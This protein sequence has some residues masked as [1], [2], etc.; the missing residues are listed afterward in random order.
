MARYFNDI[1]EKY[2]IRT[3][4]GITFNNS[5]AKEVVDYFRS[6]ELRKIEIS[7][8]ALNVFNCNRH[9]FVRVKTDKYE[10]Y[11]VRTSFLQ[12]MLRWHNL[13]VDLPSKIS[14]ETLMALLNESFH[15]IKSGNIFVNL[16][17]GEAKTVVSNYFCDLNNLEILG[18]VANQKVEKISHDD[19][20]T[21]FFTK[22]KFKMEPVVGD[23]CGFA[24]SIVNSETGFA[25]LSSEHFILRYVCTNGATASISQGKNK[26]VH[27][28]KDKDEMLSFLQKSFEEGEYGRNQ[29]I[30]K[31]KKSS[32]AG[33]IDF[34][35]DVYK[36]LKDV[37]SVYDRTSFFSE[38]DWN[39]SKYDLFNYLTSKAKEFNIT[40][41]YSI[42]K[43]AGELIN[44]SRN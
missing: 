21:R 4:S 19:Y 15:T 16:E 44:I 37:I 14:P 23:Q 12:K 40:K 18:A 36:L 29:L 8:L 7:P 2:L 41:R 17:D 1:S 26:Y 34:Q 35:L 22:E 3:K 30:E 6:R 33:A 38:F 5:P 42:E 13:P 27:Y 9:M 24:Y 25:K 31:I 11:P 28:N 39:S 10:E 43:A 20:M 32:D